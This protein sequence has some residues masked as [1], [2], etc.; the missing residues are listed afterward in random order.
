MGAAQL[1][2]GIIAIA[3][4]D[5][6]EERPRFFERRAV[7]AGRGLS[8]EYLVQVKLGIAEKLIEKSAAQALY[9]AAVAGKQR[10]GHLLGQLQTEN[11]PVVIGEKRREPFFFVGRK[12]RGHG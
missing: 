7:I 12:L 6:F 8:P 5:T 1:G 11:R 3:D 4:Q 2:D 10:P 9:R